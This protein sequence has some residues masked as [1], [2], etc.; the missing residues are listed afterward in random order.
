VLPVFSTLP[1]HL[2]TIQPLDPL[3]HLHWSLFGNHQLTSVSRS[4]TALSGMLHLTC[5]TTSSY[6]SCSLSALLHR[7][8][9]ILD[10]LLSFCIA[11][12]T[13][14]L[15]LSFFQSHFLFSYPFLN[16]APGIMTTRCLA[17]T[18]GGSMI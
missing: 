13:L 18:G 15:K 3:D 8:A 5:K 1:V 2:I 12:S 7:H 11:F 17:V 14:V 10:C 9:L 4:Q 16:V 6:S